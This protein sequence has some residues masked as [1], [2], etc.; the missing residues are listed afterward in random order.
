MFREI[1][2]I[3]SREYE[4]IYVSSVFDAGTL[5]NWGSISWIDSLPL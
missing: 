4:E 2:N 3:Y 5:A 1:G